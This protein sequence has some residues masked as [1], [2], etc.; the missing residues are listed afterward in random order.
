VVLQG[1]KGFRGPWRVASWRQAILTVSPPRGSCHRQ[2]L[3]RRVA[4]RYVPL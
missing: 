2:G 4:L 1:R 3:G